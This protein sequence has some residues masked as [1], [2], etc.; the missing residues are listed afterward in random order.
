MVVATLLLL[1]SPASASFTNGS[2]G[3]QTDATNLSFTANGITSK[4]H[5]YAGG[6]DWTQPVGIL[7]YTDGSGEYGLANPSSTYLLAGSTGLVAVAKE[8]NLMLV[9]PRAPGAGCPDGGGVC[10][11]Q[12]SS[13][14]S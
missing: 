7:I 6:L 13:G 1:G 8:H 2:G 5:R 9:T 12:T 3:S 11:Y 10:W 14:Y 4:Y